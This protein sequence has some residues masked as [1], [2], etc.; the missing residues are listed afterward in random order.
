MRGRAPIGIERMLRLYFMNLWYNFS[1]EGTKDALYGMPVLAR[2]VGIDLPS[3]QVP[4]SKRL[5]NVRHLLDENELAPNILDQVNDLLADK[6]LMLMDTTLIV[7]PHSIRNQDK[8]RDTEMDQAKK[9]KKWR[10]GMK[11]HI[12]VDVISGLPHTT[13]G[14]AANVSDVA[15]AGQLLQS[16]DKIIFADAGYK[17]ATK[18]TENEGKNVDWQVAHNLSLIHI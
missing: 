12:S 11:M 4:D 5:K 16:D 17:G 9:G 1:D 2:L 10:F 13:L 8:P 7:S 18:R 3:E 6:G 15:M 14:A